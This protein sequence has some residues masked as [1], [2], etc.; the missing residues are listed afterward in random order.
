MRSVLYEQ[1]DLRTVPPMLYVED[2][3]LNGTQISRYDSNEASASRRSTYAINRETG[4]QLL[5]HG[6]ILQ[7]PDGIRIEYWARQESRYLEPLADLHRKEVMVFS[8]REWRD[9]FC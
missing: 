5:E 9:Y 1:S 6:D 7:L 3:S 8:A 2:V 4:P